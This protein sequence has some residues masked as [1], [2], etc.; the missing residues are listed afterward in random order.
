MWDTITSRVYS[1]CL[2]IALATQT[3]RHQQGGKTGTPPR[4]DPVLPGRK[5]L[6]YC[7][8]SCVYDPH[9]LVQVS[10]T[11]QF[12]WSLCATFY[13]SQFTKCECK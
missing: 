13:C 10:L 3:Y 4:H 1:Q 6:N 8:Y 9:A 7:Y 11:Q 12:I 5:C 2:L